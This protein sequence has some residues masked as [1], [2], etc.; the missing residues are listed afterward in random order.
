[1]PLE[2]RSTCVIA[3]MKGIS[4]AVDVHRCRFSGAI[5]R[6]NAHVRHFAAA[7]PADGRIRFVDCDRFLLGEDADRIDASLMPDGVQPNAAGTAH[8]PT[9]ASTLLIL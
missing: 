3:Y 7:A 4:A 9:P 2:R 8:L 6:I 5:A 1:M